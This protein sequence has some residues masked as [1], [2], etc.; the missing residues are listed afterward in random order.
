MDKMY[1]FNEIE[2]MA[3]KGISSHDLK[4]QLRD[5]VYTLSNKAFDKGDADR[6]AVTDIAGLEKRREYARECF[7]KSFGG[8]PEPSKELGAKVTGTV[9]F[10]G[11]RVEKIIYSPRENVYVTANMYI[12]DGI[13]S[14][15]ASAAGTNAPDGIADA[16]TSAAGTN[17]AVTNAAGTSAA[18]T[19]AAVIFVCGH[20]DIGKQGA[21]YQIVCQCLVR[22]GLIVFAQDPVGQG[23]RWSYIDTEQ[24]VNSCTDEHDYAGYQCIVLGKGI[25]RYFVHDTMRAVDYLL[26]RPEVDPAKIGI[27]GCS[28]G[29]T[30]T[31]MMML[32]DRRLAAAAPSN[33]I[34][35]RRY[36]MR[37]GMAQDREQIWEGLTGWGVDHEDIILSMAPK[38]VLLLTT[39]HDFFPIEAA[40]KTYSRCERFWDMYGKRDNLEIFHDDFYHKFTVRSAMKAGSFFAKHL[41]GIDLD[42]DG[43]IDA[44]MFS[45]DKMEESDDYI[46]MLNCT[47]TGQV[48]TSIDG[49]YTVYDE[50]KRE[51]Q[52]LLDRQAADNKTDRQRYEEQRLAGLRK[53]GALEFLRERIYKNRTDVGNYYLKRWLDATPVDGGLIAE[54][55]YWMSQE[56]VIETGVVFKA[57]EDAGRRLPVTVA[58]WRGGSYD[59]SGHAEF[60]QKSCESGRAVFVYD[61]TG[62]GMTSQRV[63]N[64]TDDIYAFYGALFKL[65]DDLLWLGDSLA[66]LRTH[67]LLRL[68]N[69]IGGNDAFDAGGG[70]EIYTHGRYSV[71]ADLAK[72]VVGGDKIENVI[73]DEPLIS[74][75]EFINNR[76]YDRSDIAGVILPGMLDYADLDDIRRFFT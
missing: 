37:S 21:G 71:Y 46:T 1:T 32:T 22:A 44:T 63:I 16:G 35:N 27:T 6:D 20:W 5:Y 38:P 39:I 56:D 40:E 73:S 60:I 68:V 49:A 72:F 10:D 50:N 69:I 31:S 30:Q 15:G 23:E 55:F 18:G 43:Y 74:Y 41:L 58:M 9:Q 48:Q 2:R 70:I 11:Y 29:G 14:N 42:P 25:T 51:L 28:G 52:R 26:S 17:V 57:K 54:G 36:Y 75:K 4:D 53:E 66:A 12:P 8:L 13:K 24:R 61:V 62:T 19:N 34:M 45:E 76:F 7:I 64:F 59:L 47:P 33:F 65:N 67:G 3:S